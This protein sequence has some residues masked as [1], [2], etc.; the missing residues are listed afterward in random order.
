[1][2]RLAAVLDAWQV[3]PPRVWRL[4]DPDSATLAL[5][6]G[7]VLGCPVELWSA[8]GATGAGLVVAYDLATLSEET[9]ASLREHRPGQALWAHAACWTDEPPCAADLT[10]YL[11][12]CNV[13]PW[14]ERLRLNVET[15]ESEKVPASKAPPEGRAAE[16]LAASLQADALTDLPALVELAR[17][18]QRLEGE[19]GPGALRVDGRRRRQGTNSP[20]LSSR[21]C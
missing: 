4:D 13:S 16:V 8:D 15:R 10:T 1:L 14:G 3:R 7:T 2:R 21:F 18:S 12:Q 20:V 19:H 17:A 6:A 5:A 9:I 11:C